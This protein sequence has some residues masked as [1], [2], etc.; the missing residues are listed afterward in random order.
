MDCVRYL[1]RYRT[2]ST[3]MLLCIPVR[4]LIINRAPQGFH[5]CSRCGFTTSLRL[6]GALSLTAAAVSGL[7]LPAWPDR[8]GWSSHRCAHGSQVAEPSCSVLLTECLHEQDRPAQRSVLLVRTNPRVRDPSSV[9]FSRTV[10]LHL[11]PLPAARQTGAI[12]L[13]GDQNYV[14]THAYSLLVYT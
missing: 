13:Q 12:D 4:S 8:H 14:S 3:R 9:F 6:M 2:Q 7:E 1:A 11:S 10:T 5:R